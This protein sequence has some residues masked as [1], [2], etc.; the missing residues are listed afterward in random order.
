MDSIVGPFRV[1]YVQF[2]IL[3][4]V[5]HSTGG[6]LL[7]ALGGPHCV[8][9]ALQRALLN[10]PFIHYNAQLRVNY[11]D[12]WVRAH[13]QWC[14]SDGLL[15]YS[16]HE[17]LLHMGTHHFTGIPTC[18]WTSNCSFLLFRWTNWNSHLV[19]FIC[20]LSCKE[21]I[22]IPPSE[23]SL[24]LSF[25]WIFHLNISLSYLG[26]FFLKNM[27]MHACSIERTSILIFSFHANISEAWICEYV[28]VFPVNA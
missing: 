23:Q 19:P 2:Y 18:S 7:L 20:E 28:F 21:R 27:C 9:C 25:H 5:C 1:L 6:S 17:P 8:K 16:T 26:R 12:T 10:N 13:T 14:L 4:H 3:L 22:R 15:W 11:L 24:L